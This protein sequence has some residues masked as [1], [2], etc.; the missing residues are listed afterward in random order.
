M[1]RLPKPILPKEVYEFTEE[2]WISFE[3]SCK[4]IPQKCLNEKPS[5]KNV[6]DL[7]DQ[8]PTE[9]D[10]S[11]QLPTGEYLLTNYPGIH[12]LSQFINGRAVINF[13]RAWD[14]NENKGP[15][16]YPST[17]NKIRVINI[18]DPNEKKL[19][20]EQLKS[21][22]ETLFKKTNI[23]TKGDI[24]IINQRLIN[25]SGLEVFVNEQRT[26]NIELKHRDRI[27]IGTE[28]PPEIEFIYLISQPY[29][30]NQLKN[31]QTNHPP[32]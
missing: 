31:H 22:Y 18:P 30:Q 19:T 28:Y 7:S 1:K 17:S 23:F 32:S 26:N 6:E 20:E 2:D 25:N 14:H 5:K 16:D 11:D 9:E 12:P 15:Q 13:Y 21:L 27:G 29:S 3:D 8:L 4:E 10:L 24:K